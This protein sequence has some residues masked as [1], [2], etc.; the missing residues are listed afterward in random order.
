MLGG[1]A[2]RGG[3][4]SLRESKAEVKSTFPQYDCLL[5]PRKHLNGKPFHAVCWTLA[6]TRPTNPHVIYLTSTEMGCAYCSPPSNHGNPASA[7]RAS[8]G[9]LRVTETA[10]GQKIYPWG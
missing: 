10:E 8:G 2:A 4:R 6:S 1:H 5:S 7:A 9:W 3:I